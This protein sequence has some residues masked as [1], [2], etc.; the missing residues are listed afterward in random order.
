MTQ[1]TSN[2]NTTISNAIN[3]GIQYS[4]K[5]RGTHARVSRVRVTTVGKPSFSEKQ[6][7]NCPRCKESANSVKMLTARVGRIEYLVDALAKTTHSLTLMSKREDRF[8]Q[9]N[10][11]FGELDL[12]RCSLQELQKL[13]VATTNIMVPSKKFD[14]SF[15]SPTSPVN[16]NTAMTT[17]TNAE[18]ETLVS[19]TIYSEPK[20]AKDVKVMEDVKTHQDQQPITPTSPV[21]TATSTLKRN[22]SLR[23]DSGFEESKHISPSDRTPN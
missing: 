6:L 19:K 14:Q 17:T 21:K 5:A 10:L 11:R 1:H 4:H 15:P 2:K 16:N 9:Y 20:D 12:T 8:A 23:Q 3:S 18:K 7:R 22:K 13:V